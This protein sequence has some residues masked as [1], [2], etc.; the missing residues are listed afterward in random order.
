MTLPI[1]ADQARRLVLHLQGLSEPGRGRLSRDGLLEII[2]RIGFVQ[3]DS[4]S[5]VERAHHM[6]LLA[7]H[8]G[9]R[10]EF[11]R[12][13]LEDE[14]RL[15]EHWTHDVAAILPLRFYPYWK[16]RFERERATVEQRFARWF[17]DGFRGELDRVLAQVVE[18]GP[19][20]ARDL[21]PDAAREAGG[22]WQW[23]AGKAALEFLWR[24][25]RLAVARRAGFQKVYDLA[26]RVIPA[27]VRGVE[28]DHQALV[29]WACRA[30][31]DRLGFATPGELARFFGLAT[32][33]EA[34]RW[35]REQL[36]HAAL[37]VQVGAVNGAT[38]RQLIARP[39]I[40]DLL[41]AL[42]SPSGHIRVLSPF[43]PLLRD[44]AR[45]ERL[46]GFDYRIEVFVPA[47]RRTYGYYVFPLLEGDRLVGRIDMRADRQR[48]SLAVD[49][50]WMEPGAR[51]GTLRRRRLE[52]E[53]DRI[54]RF[55]GAEATTFADGFLKR[56]G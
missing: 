38:P 49:A 24:T 27:A 30:A 11:L 32:L 52:A 2:E 31:L 35:C 36:G 18:R 29:D 10:P 13:L 26:E 39:D 4:I 50:L 6:I 46:F 20:M 51:L 41:E 37:A 25:G 16:L 44:R 19:T 12:R 28:P 23:H 1:C 17:G 3:V 54:R 15:F 22:W 40:A 47:R 45:L 8:R 55:V 9:Y 53:L 5:T 7:R 42:P 33:D 14:V 34:T 48:R 43:D 21:A 56:D